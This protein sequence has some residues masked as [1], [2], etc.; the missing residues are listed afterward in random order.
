MVAGASDVRPALPEWTQSDVPF[1]TIDDA[2]SALGDVPM[3]GSADV[4][5]L[6]TKG[7]VWKV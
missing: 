6:L 5:Q 7:T 2:R 1:I 3:Y 4:L